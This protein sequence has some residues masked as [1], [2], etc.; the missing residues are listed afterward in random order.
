MCLHFTETPVNNLKTCSLTKTTLNHIEHCVNS[1]IRLFLRCSFILMEI[2]FLGLLFGFPAVG[3]MKSHVCHLYITSFW[4]FYSTMNGHTL[5]SE[6]AINLLIKHHPF[7]TKCCCGATC[8]HEEVFT[9]CVCVVRWWWRLPVRAGYRRGVPSVVSG[10]GG[11]GE[12][13]DQ[14]GDHTV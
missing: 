8:A 4:A 10:W 14:Q 11:P 3:Q 7:G 5:M 1:P 13:A 2:D 6:D 12:G 9:V